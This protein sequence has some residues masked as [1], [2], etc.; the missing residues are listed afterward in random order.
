[1]SDR[2][3]WDHPGQPLSRTRDLSPDGRWAL[4]LGLMAL[5]VGLSA[6]AGGAYLAVGI[7]TRLVSL[8]AGLPAAPSETV[9]IV[10]ASCGSITMLL[11][12]ISLYR[13]HDA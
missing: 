5:A 3:F 8:P 13:A 2:G 4:A 6:M 10:L 9:A 7:S 12:I 11:G 1:M